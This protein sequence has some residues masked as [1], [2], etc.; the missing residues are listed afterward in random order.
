MTHPN[1]HFIDRI[2]K[3][4]M[5]LLK[6][7]DYKHL[8]TK[9]LLDKQYPIILNDIIFEI[10]YKEIET[11]EVGITY[12]K[13]NNNPEI[14]FNQMN[15]PYNL[16]F[17]TDHDNY[18]SIHKQYFSEFNMSGFPLKCMRIRIYKN[19]AINKTLNLRC[20][21]F[22][23]EIYH[24]IT[25]LNYDVPRIKSLL[26]FN[27]IRCTRFIP[28]SL[29]MK[30]NNY[31]FK[32]LEGLYKKP[33]YFGPNGN[34]HQTRLLEGRLS[35]STINT[36]IISLRDHYQFQKKLNDDMELFP[37]FIHNYHLYNIYFS[38]DHKSFVPLAYNPL[39]NPIIK[40]D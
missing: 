25:C 3:N 38:M 29:K 33:P 20:S 28:I 5:D 11:N 15:E 34:N 19:D 22:E 13:N 12:N 32:N 2:K 40:L 14:I 1:N 21:T 36:Q 7:I 8:V 26:N 16:I 39:E 17:L 23:E 18:F 35:N 9:L 37:E 24:F 10:Y 27:F 4:N 30:V 6:Y 31:R